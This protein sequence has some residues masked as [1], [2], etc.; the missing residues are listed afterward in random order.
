M[1]QTYASP[2]RPLRPW[3]AVRRELLSKLLGTALPLHLEGQVAYIQAQIGA[4]NAPPV[5]AWFLIDTA[6]TQS[7]V[8]LSLIPQT[9]RPSSASSTDSQIYY[10]ETFQFFGSWDKVGFHLSDYSQNKATVKQ[11]GIIGTDFLSQ[12]PYLFDYVEKKLYR[13]EGYLNCSFGELSD[14]GLVALS[15]QGYYSNIAPT[16]MNSYNVRV[17][18]VPT[19]PVKIGSETFMAQVDSGYNDYKY[20]FSINI[21]TALK[22]ALD[23]AGV[24]LIA[25]PELN[26]TLSTCVPGVRDQVTAF[27]LGA[28]T[29]FTFLD[30][31]GNSINQFKEVNLFLKTT[32][33]EA[34]ICGGISTW[35][36]PA[37]Q[38][39]AS[40]LKDAGFVIFDPLNGLVWIPKTV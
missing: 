29:F 4:L 31:G 20:P 10:P 30:V 32:P 23:A 33:E 38:L 12:Q 37:A 16:V 8:D 40:F 26:S 17:P 7:Y 5:P 27:R 28:D 19:V 18:N 35:D 21:N 1:I 15:T 34:K 6:T 3:Q 13:S 25:V 11:S 36:K 2:A 24:Q 14:A 22:K 9:D 39:G